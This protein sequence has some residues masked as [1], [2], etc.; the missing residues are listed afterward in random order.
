MHLWTLFKAVTRMEPM[1]LGTAAT[2]HHC[3]Y[4]FEPLLC[5]FFS[6]A[7]N[8]TAFLFVWDLFVGMYITVF[9]IAQPYKKRVYNITDTLILMA[10]LLIIVSSS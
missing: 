1:E 4:F 7:K 9:V 2:C 10:L 5:F 8:P 6:F 3:T